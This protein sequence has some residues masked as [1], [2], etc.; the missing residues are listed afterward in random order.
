META[1]FSTKHL[2]IPTLES[3]GHIHC[4][5]VWRCDRRHNLALYFYWLRHIIKCVLQKRR[6]HLNNQFFGNAQ[7]LDY[8]LGQIYLKTLLPNLPAWRCR[9][10]LSQINLSPAL[11]YKH[12]IFTGHMSI[13]I[14]YSSKKQMNEFHLIGQVTSEFDISLCFSLLFLILLSRKAKT[15]I[16]NIQH[17]LR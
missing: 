16:P 17:I 13:Y 14:L 9:H 8:S 5:F 10:I 6:L 2:T 4:V 15:L 12:S 7:L 11:Y 3:L 1:A